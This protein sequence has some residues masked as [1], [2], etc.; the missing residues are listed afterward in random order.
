MECRV[1][2]SCYS[3]SS[4]AGRGARWEWAR[5]CAPPHRDLLYE[6]LPMEVLHLH[7][8]IHIGELLHRVVDARARRALCLAHELGSSILS[9]VMDEYRRSQTCE[10]HTLL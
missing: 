9:V 4:P 5:L 10:G 7:T 2:R 8:H 6:P 3:V 1:R